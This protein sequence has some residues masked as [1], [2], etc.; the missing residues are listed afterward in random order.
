MTN[1]C[2]IYESH[3]TDTNSLEEITVH[4]KTRFITQR[5]KD[6]IQKIYHKIG[7]SNGFAIY[8]YEKITLVAK[9]QMQLPTYAKFLLFETI[10]DEIQKSIGAVL[11]TVDGVIQ[12]SISYTSKWP[13]VNNALSRTYSF[14][15]KSFE[16]GMNFIGNF[17]QDV[18]DE[19]LIKAI[20]NTYNEIRVALQRLATDLIIGLQSWALDIWN[21][22]EQAW[23]T[24]TNSIKNFLHKASAW[25][26]D[27]W[28][29]A[30]DFLKVVGKSV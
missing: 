13:E 10:S 7:L 27:A 21:N 11:T 12:S 18:K 6:G 25:I 29:K 24:L 1:T 4:L 28:H 22:V 5:D 20:V 23:I 15:H 8:D 16:N 26:E 9:K 14:L 17:T 19:G 2:K 30:V 3:P